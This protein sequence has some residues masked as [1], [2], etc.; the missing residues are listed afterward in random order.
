MIVYLDTSVVLRMLLNQENRW[1]QWGRWKKAYSSALL[2]L[3]C[4]RAI[5]RCRL[6]SAFDD[7]QVAHA[8]DE[9]R[10]LQ[11]V[12]GR[13]G[14][15]RSVMDRASQPMP[16]LVRTLDALHLAS[17]LLLREKLHPDVV[18]VTHDSRQAVAA[19]ALSFECI[20]G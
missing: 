5:D 12:V 6:E 2:Y 7:L 8:G 20:E 19:R 4:R 13:I 9:I 14:L 10:R 11:R 18:F 15:T 3:E 17:A 16:T 1:K